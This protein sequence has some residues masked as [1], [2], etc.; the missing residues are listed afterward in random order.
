MC[1]RRQTSREH[2]C[3]LRV[4]ENHGGTLRQE[5]LTTLVKTH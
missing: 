4:L 1:W 2:L 3:Q 5:M